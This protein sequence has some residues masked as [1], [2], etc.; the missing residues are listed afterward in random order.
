M[1]AASDQQKTWNIPEQCLPFVKEK[2]SQRPRGHGSTKKY[3]EGCKVFEAKNE[4]SYILLGID[5]LNN[6]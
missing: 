6:K 5:F 1:S 2:C 4:N 3:C